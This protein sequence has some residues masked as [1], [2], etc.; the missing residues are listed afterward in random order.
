MKTMLTFTMISLI[1]VAFIGP[2]WADC[3]KRV[4]EARESIKQAEAAVAKAKDSGKNAAK[5]PLGKAKKQLLHAEAECKTE[6][7]V[8]KQ[9]EAVREAREAQGYAEEAL[10]LAERL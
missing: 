6:K 8:R 7:D 9:A 3:A 1:G 10:M 4:D 2:V 5:G